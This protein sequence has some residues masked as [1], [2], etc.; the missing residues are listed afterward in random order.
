MYRFTGANE[1]TTMNN[2]MFMVC[3]VMLTLSTA[4][5]QKKSGSDACKGTTQYELNV[6]AGE[7][8][9]RADK[10][11]NRVYQ[12]LLKK[13]QV[14]N[15]LR[16]RSNGQN[17]HGSCTVTPISKR[18]I[19]QK[20]SKERSIYPMEWALANT[21]LTKAHTGA[22]KDLLQAYTAEG[23]SQGDKEQ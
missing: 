3:A 16:R 1:G 10:E 7:Q 6:C 15:W 23:T 9:K 18:C 17:R 20:T 11:L 21:K 22:L 4:P 2:R 12:Q 14:T 13:P 5:I 19:R 8:F